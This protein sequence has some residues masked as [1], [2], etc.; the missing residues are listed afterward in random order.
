M[1]LAGALLVEAP[2]SASEEATVPVRAV[3]P[4][5]E[6]PLPASA[7]ERTVEAVLGGGLAVPSAGPLRAPAEEGF[8]WLA[9]VSR[10]AAG[11]PSPVGWELL[12]VDGTPPRVDLAVT[13][14]PVAAVD[15]RGWVPNGATLIASAE[16]DLSAVVRTAAAAAGDPIEAEGVTASVAIEGTRRELLILTGWAEDEAGNR[17]GEARL[18]VLLDPWP[19]QGRIECVGRCAGA[20][21]GWIIAPDARFEARVADPDSGL[22]STEL[23]V[24]GAAAGA[25]GWDGPWD[26]EAYELSVA[27]A[28]RVGNADRIG[29]VQVTVDRTG[30]ELTWERDRSGDLRVSATDPAGI[31]DLEWSRRGTAWWRLRGPMPRRFLARLDELWLRATDRVGN[32]TEVEVDLTEKGGGR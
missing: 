8:H 18:E 23:E 13:P 2:P 25:A 22:A 26:G 21:A 3:A 16:D 28:D 27:A 5:A 12:L 11:N 9:L 10:D 20:G 32:R 17:S 24:D 19:P 15:G 29:P 14:S 6:V 30:P 31:G 1:L 7:P 4:G